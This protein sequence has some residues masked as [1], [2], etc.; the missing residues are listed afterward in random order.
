M[1]YTKT[2]NNN[3]KPRERLS[4][5]V[6]SGSIKIGRTKRKAHK[7]TIKNGSR[8]IL[9]GYCESNHAPNPMAKLI[10]KIASKKVGRSSKEITSPLGLKIMARDAIP[11]VNKPR[12]EIIRS[13]KIL[14]FCVFIVS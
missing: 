1:P 11:M 6:E 5:S 12:P 10:A 2:S 9:R 14:F 3:E 7:V 13:R 8:N 4:I